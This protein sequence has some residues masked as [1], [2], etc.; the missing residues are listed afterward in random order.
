[1][2]KLS[3]KFKFKI[4]SK[5]VKVSKM[6]DNFQFLN[7]QGMFSFSPEQTAKCNAQGAEKKSTSMPYICREVYK[8]LS[9][10][11]SVM[12]LGKKFVISC[13]GQ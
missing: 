13:I 9:A 12:R 6:T 8:T 4:W 10:S 7:R 2:K 11:Y 3:R 1:M 5:I